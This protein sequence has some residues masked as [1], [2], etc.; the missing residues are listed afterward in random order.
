LFQKDT[1]ELII[2]PG[3]LSENDETVT[4]KFCIFD[5]FA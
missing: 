5:S 3:Y 4:N 2:K 1:K